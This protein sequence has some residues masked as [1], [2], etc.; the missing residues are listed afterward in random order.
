MS[1]A[2]EGVGNRVGKRRGG[3]N[4]SALFPAPPPSLLIR[5]FRACPSV[6][7]RAVL[8][9]FLSR[10]QLVALA[11]FNK[12]PSDTFH[13]RE[14]ASGSLPE[15]LCNVKFAM[16][17]RNARARG[18]LPD[19]FSL[20]LRVAGS[21]FALHLRSIKISKRTRVSLAD[22]NFEMRRSRSLLSLSFSLLPFYPP[23]SL[24]LSLFASLPG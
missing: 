9:Q 10:R 8:F 21:F 24:S 6:R 5:H 13:P 11:I 16:C 15:E 2:I 1:F 14:I 7:A 18:N 20:G 4:E 22:P 12:W 19:N 23:L 3:G 17:G